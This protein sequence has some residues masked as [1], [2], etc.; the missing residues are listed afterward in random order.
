VGAGQTAPQV[1][2]HIK[3]KPG[4]PDLTGYID[5]H[6]QQGVQASDQRSSRIAGMGVYNRG[7]GI[8]V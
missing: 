7:L 4:A 2:V 6:V 1:H 5:V 3:S 8:G